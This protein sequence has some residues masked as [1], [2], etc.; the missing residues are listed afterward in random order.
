MTCTPTNLV[1]P[2]ASKQYSSF[3]SK[4]NFCMNSMNRP[5]VGITDYSNMYQNP[6]LINNI[7]YIKS[8]NS[9]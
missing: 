1:T 4:W 8:M 2:L 9:I 3:A 7:N 6:F 5:E